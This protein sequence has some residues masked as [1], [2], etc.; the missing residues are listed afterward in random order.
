[1]MPLKSLLFPFV[2]T[3]GAQK[4]LIGPVQSVDITRDDK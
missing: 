3:A 1:M 4:C 2:P